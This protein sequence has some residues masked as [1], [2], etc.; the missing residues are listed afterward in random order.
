MTVLQFDVIESLVNEGESIIGEFV[1]VDGNYASEAIFW[2]VG[3][4]LLVVE[5]FITHSDGSTQFYNRFVVDEYFD[6]EYSI[7]YS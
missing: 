7:Y 4:Q 2:Y 6:Y 1:S 3:D 5:P